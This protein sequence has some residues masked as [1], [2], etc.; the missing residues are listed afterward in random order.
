MKVPTQSRARFLVLKFTASAGSSLQFQTRWG[1]LEKLNLGST[2][3]A[4]Q[5][6]ALVLGS[7]RTITWTDQR[8]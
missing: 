3:A 6:S 2:W 1:F 4:V 5:R 8:R 7:A